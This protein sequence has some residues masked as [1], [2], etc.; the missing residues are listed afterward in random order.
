MA[1]TNGTG[2][3]AAAAAVAA[4]DPDNV[5]RKR[6]PS[7]KEQKALKKQRKGAPP[8]SN[9]ANIAPLAAATLTD[10]MQKVTATTAQEATPD[11]TN[12]NTEDA[13]AKEITNPP[14]DYL[15]DYQPV[16]VPK[17]S[18]TDS[19]AAAA[20]LGKWFPKAK[21]MKSKVCYSND[22][23]TSAKA[24][25]LLFYQY[26]NW[27]EETVTR[28][29]DYLQ[30]LGS[31]RVLGGRIRVAPEGI[32]A[33]VSSVDAPND[34]GDNNNIIRTAARTL[35]HFVQ[36]L[37]T[38][39]PV[40]AKTDFKYIDHLSSDRHFKDLK[41]LPVKELVFYGIGETQAPLH[42]GG[43]HLS[44]EDFHAKLAQPNTV[45]VD[46]R[47]H[48]EADIGRFDGQCQLDTGGATYMDPKMR[49]STDF[50]TWLAQAE[51]KDAL[52]KKQVLLFC[53]GGVRCERASA[54]LN[55]Q[56]GDSIQG[57]YQLQG[58][59]ERYLQTFEDGGY[60]RGKNFV[61]DKREAIGPG[62]INGDGGIVMVAAKNNSTK[63]TEKNPI[64]AKCC[65]CTKPWDRY[66]GKKKCH[67][68]G[69]PVLMC[70]SCMTTARTKEQMVVARCPLCV[71]QDITVPA[72]DVE[73]TNNGVNVRKEDGGDHSKHSVAASSVLKWGGGHAT[74]KKEKRKLKR[75]LC[76]FGAECIRNDC[77]FS[78]PDRGNTKQKKERA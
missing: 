26:A 54:Y 63:S 33:T 15:S 32:N 74:E 48:Y 4:V 6:R 49:K 12:N 18:N 53:T 72:T 5:S 67:M 60:W 9:P 21:T 71:E 44:A 29:M 43:T 52:Q 46:V 58:G 57:C 38:F 50:A 20:S 31:A 1:N 56:M 68:C 76:Q 22:K 7:R 17:A 61:F 65:L 25:L 36:D 35:R 75:R 23:K 34:D 41:L 14:I 42:M 2:R 73:Y 11:D 70:D 37:Q 10:S 59:V 24:S 66:L 78:H 55:Q 69:V 8:H 45:V 30:T 39:D 3:A 27:N 19:T 47:N 28:I 40:F 13:T 77:F 62:N 51:T 64:G 16:P